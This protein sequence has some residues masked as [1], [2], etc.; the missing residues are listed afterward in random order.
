MNSFL[1]HYVFQ[2]K[3]VSGESF[4]KIHINQALNNK[5]NWLDFVYTYA[6]EYS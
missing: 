2:A 3:D 6:S 4:W 1:F 5:L